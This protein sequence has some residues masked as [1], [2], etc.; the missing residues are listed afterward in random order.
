MPEDKHTAPKRSRS[1]KKRA[2]DAKYRA[3][4]KEETRQYLKKYYEENKAAIN[5]QKKAYN[6]ANAD[7]IAE[8]LRLHYQENREAV[9][10]NN[11]EYRLANR[12]AI[13]ERRR[14]RYKRDHPERPPRKLDWNNKAEKRA[15]MLVWRAQNREKRRESQR[16]Y[17]AE[18][19][20]FKSAC[21]RRYYEN[22][23][24]DPKRL[25]DWKKTASV[26]AERNREQIAA[27][28]A[29]AYQRRRAA[30]PEKVR[31]TGRENA[32]RA[33]RSKSEEER[34][35]L[36]A[37]RINYQQQYREAN[38]ESLTERAAERHEENK[39]EANAKSRA[40]Y[41]QNK[42][43]FIKRA[44]YRRTLLTG[45]YTQ[46]DLDALYVAQ[47]GRCPA[48]KVDLHGVYT[49]DH[50]MPLALDKYG[51]VLENLQLMCS[52]CNHK[53]YKKHPDVWAAYCKKH[54][55]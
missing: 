16:K 34:K 53:K 24:T 5:E 21:D 36:Y 49:I 13:G 3:A 10:K 50:I 4:H 45:T 23:K 22:V 40:Y 26:Y 51:D 31:A 52:T 47:K 54:F 44:N 1:E 11:R 41:Q 25:A 17:E 37:G 46:S 28:S 30:D 42:L 32:N 2:G 15:Y 9:L 20:G 18:H 48:C 29:E 14:E 35:T 6:L 55:A 27:Q 43:P 12:E 19:P 39:V 7:A 33:Y 8:R 38:Q